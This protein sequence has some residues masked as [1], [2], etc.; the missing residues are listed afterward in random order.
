MSIDV[1]VPVYNGEKY[2][3]RCIWSVFVNSERCPE[4]KK[5]K[6]T[7]VD[8][9][10][11]DETVKIVKNLGF[12]PDFLT[13]LSQENA[14]VGAARNLGL[15]QTSGDFVMFLDADDWLP[16][17]AIED[18]TRDASNYGSDIVF[19]NSHNFLGKIPIGKTSETWHKPE[20]GIIDP[21]ENNFLVEITPGV[22]SKLFRREAFLGARFPNERIKWEDLAI[23]PALIAKAKKI[24]YVD[25][26]VYNYTIHANT[27]VKDFFVKCNVLDIIKSADLLKENLEKFG[28]YDE[29]FAEYNSILTLHTLFRAENIITWQKVIRAHKRELTHQLLADLK[30]R[31]PGWKNDPVL[32]SPEKRYKDPFFN[33]MLSRLCL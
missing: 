16:K 22:R 2:I 3:E 18:L 23:I 29:F 24:S 12:S 31:Y 6:L 20:P 26:V 33:F 17:D 28:V 5:V 25:D 15:D 21:H 9:G 7:L 1:I 13:I 14:G 19:G 4:Y 27:T 30:K 11:T 8:D 10:S 32:R